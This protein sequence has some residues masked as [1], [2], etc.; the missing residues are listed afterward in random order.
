MTTK[1]TPLSF[2]LYFISPS[3]LCLFKIRCLTEYSNQCAIDLYN[4]IVIFSFLFSIAFLTQ[5]N[6]LF[7]FLITTE[8]VSSLNCLQ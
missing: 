7:A 1:V 5:F 2:S 6:V 8:Q 4:G 3:H